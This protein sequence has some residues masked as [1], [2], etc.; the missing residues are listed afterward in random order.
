MKKLCL[1][2]LA[3][4]FF[5][6]LSA[7]SAIDREKERPEDTDPSRGGGNPGLSFCTNYFYCYTTQFTG[8]ESYKV[9]ITKK[10]P[11]GGSPIGVVGTEIEYRYTHVTAGSPPTYTYYDWATAGA[12]IVLYGTNAGGPINIMVRERLPGSSTWTLYPV[13]YCP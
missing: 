6:L 13:S 12:P 5:L 9:V 4:L 7:F 1:T 3:S 10:C 11:D 2:G 8:P